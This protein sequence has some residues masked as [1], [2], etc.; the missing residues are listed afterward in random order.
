VQAARGPPDAG[1]R[2]AGRGSGPATGAH[3]HEH[4]HHPAFATWSFSGD[5]P[6]SGTGLVEAIAAF[7]DGIVRAKGFLHLLEDPATRYVLQLVGRR[8]T[9]QPE[10]PWG[11]D[12][13]CS[14]LV[15]I[16]LPDSIDPPALDATLARLGAAPAGG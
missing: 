7:P 11:D 8:Y 13:A 9:I 5:A 4:D 6:L 16:G 14:R 12:P 3:D 10:R 1:G 15:V 2:A